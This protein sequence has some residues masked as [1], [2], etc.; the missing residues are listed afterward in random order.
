MLGFHSSMFGIN[1]NN[2]KQTVLNLGNFLAF[3]WNAMFN[4]LN[5]LLKRIPCIKIYLSLF[6]FFFKTSPC[7]EYVL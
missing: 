7:K 5:L 3:H 6:P 1:Q 4:L 2:N